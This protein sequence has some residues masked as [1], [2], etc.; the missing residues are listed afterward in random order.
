LSLR[1]FVQALSGIGSGY[2]RKIPDTPNIGHR[3]AGIT[4]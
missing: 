1:L 4:A 3:R 2:F